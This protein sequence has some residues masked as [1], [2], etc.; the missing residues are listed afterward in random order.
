MFWLLR[1]HFARYAAWIGRQGEKRPKYTRRDSSYLAGLHSRRVET[2]LNAESQNYHFSL[3]ESNSICLGLP[4]WRFQLGL[5]PF[6]WARLG[7][8]Y[9]RGVINA[10]LQMKKAHCPRVAG[11]HQFHGP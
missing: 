7:S 10:S 11:S 8:C 9:S 5:T 3:G 6:N 2:R 4:S 1:V